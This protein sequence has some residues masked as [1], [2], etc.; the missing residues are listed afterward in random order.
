MAAR[1]TATAP[2]K[3]ARPR[4]SVNFMDILDAELAQDDVT[5]DDPDDGASDVL[6]VNH[7]LQQLNKAKGKVPPENLHRMFG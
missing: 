2:S 7:T 6:E 3:D 1:E 4:R 5:S